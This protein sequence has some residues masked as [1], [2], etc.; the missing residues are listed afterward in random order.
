M[1]LV[2]RSGTRNSSC[3]F[4]GKNN[5]TPRSQGGLP[6]IPGSFFQKRDSLEQTRLSR[7]TNIHPRGHFLEQKSLEH[8]VVSGNL[9]IHGILKRVQIARYWSE[10]DPY[11]SFRK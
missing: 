5:S 6:E 1:S 7:S 10:S 4:S 8:A 2:P 9:R 11:D 3:H